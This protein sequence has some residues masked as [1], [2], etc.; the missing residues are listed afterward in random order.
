L[1]DL[2]TPVAHDFD[3]R[4][5]RRLT[6]EFL[7]HFC[8]GGFASSLATITKSGL[9]PLDLRTR[10]DAKSG[11]EHVT[12]YTGLTAVLQ[13]LSS[14]NG[15]IRLAAHS[16]HQKQGTFDKAWQAARTVED[17]TTLW[18]EVELYLERVIPAASQSHGRTEG[19]VQAAIGSYRD[20]PP[21]RVSAAHHVPSPV[22]PE[23]GSDEPDRDDDQGDEG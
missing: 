9:Y 11:A 8:P 14:K 19:A 3:I 22:A 4:Y 5:D 16:T 20:D 23:A 10:R 6:P 21:Q 12:L 1:T 17:W 13:V 2:E 18:P 7:A 15:T